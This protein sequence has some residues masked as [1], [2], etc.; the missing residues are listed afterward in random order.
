[1]RTRRYFISLALA[2][3]AA[4]GAVLA[5]PAPPA[6][7][8]AAYQRF[9]PLLI[10]LSGWSGDKAEG[11]AMEMSGASMTAATR[12]YERGEARIEAQIM[13]GPA[14]Q[15]ALAMTGAEMKIESSDGRMSSAELDGFQ[16]TRTYTFSDKS[17]G[18]LVALRANALF[19]LSFSGIA[20]DEALALAKEFDWK[21]MQA[22]VGQ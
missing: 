2:A 21:A 14:A 12:N 8:E 3:A 22:A 6:Q 7:A 13:T 15:G 9:V 16:V 18:I 17:G 20:D 5:L 10:D 1:M 19:S 4:L 11:M